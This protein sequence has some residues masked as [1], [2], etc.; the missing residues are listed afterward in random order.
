[1][2]QEQTPEEI[3]VIKQLNKLS[4][5]TPISKYLAVALFIVLPFIGG[6]IGYMYAPEK[7]VEVVR[8]VEVEKNVDVEKSAM[9]EKEA[10]NNSRYDESFLKQKWQSLL[11]G[12]GHTFII[13]DEKVYSVTGAVFGIALEFYELQHFS[14]E[15]FVVLGET[16]WGSYISDGDGVFFLARSYANEFSEVEPKLLVGVEKDDFEILTFINVVKNELHF[17]KTD[18]KIFYKEKILEELDPDNTE[19][20][21]YNMSLYNENIL[22]EP[23]YG[24]AISDY[25]KGNREDFDPSSTNGPC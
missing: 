2:E 24:C 15:N 7:V 12:D 4:T 21:A 5:V 10:A 18:D 22:W 9:V 25:I 17:G 19:F 16:H 1:M 6:W 3:V 11:P 13:Q 20:N 8:I 23:D 14:P